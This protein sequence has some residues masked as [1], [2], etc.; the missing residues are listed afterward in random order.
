MD[1][2]HR[3]FRDSEP[4]V[5][6]KDLVRQTVGLAAQPGSCNPPGD[7]VGFDVG[8]RFERGAL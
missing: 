5:D 4:R 6:L 1:L 7:F 3:H 8:S 2:E